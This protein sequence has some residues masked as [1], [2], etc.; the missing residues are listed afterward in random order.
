MKVIFLLTLGKKTGGKNPQTEL[1]IAFSNIYMIKGLRIWYDKMWGQILNGS[2]FK[3]NTKERRWNSNKR[4]CENGRKA[5]LINFMEKE[6]AHKILK[7]SICQWN[8]L[9]MKKKIEVKKTANKEFARSLLH[10][11]IVQPL[12]NPSTPSPTHPLSLH[13]THASVQVDRLGCI[14]FSRS[15]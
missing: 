6:D 8:Y 12:I 10:K 1:T 5:F 13:N 7:L 14:I 3:D 9:S 15:Y 2:R 11:M 4:R